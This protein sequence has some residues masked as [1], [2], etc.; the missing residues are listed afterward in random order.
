MSAHA[1]AGTTAAP[2]GPERRPVVHEH[3]GDRR[4]DEYAWLRDRDDPAVIAHLEAENA[5]TEASLAHIEP[6]RE[7]LYQEIVARIQETDASAPVP[8]GPFLYWTRTEQGHQYAVHCRR[9]REPADAAAEV[10]LDVNALAEGHDFTR[11]GD[12]AVSP[13]HSLLAHTVDHAGNERHSLRIRDL[14][15]GVDLDDVVEGV[16]Y[17]LAWASDSRTV[18]YTRPDHAMRPHQVWRHRVGTDPESDALVHQEDDERFFVEVSRT[19]S[20]RWILIELGSYTTSEAWLVPA[21][22][23]ATPPRVVSARRPGVEYSVDH[24]VDAEGRERLYIVTNDG[25][26][27]FRLVE[28]PIDATEHHHWSPVLPHDEGVRLERISCFAGFLAVWERAA[29]LRRV[30]TLCLPHAGR[31]PVELEQPEPV[32]TVTPGDN[33]EWATSTLR[34]EFTSLVTPLQTVEHDVVTG[35]RAV[36]KQVPVLGGYD[37]LRYRSERLWATAPDGVRVPMSVVRR[38]DVPA[39]GTAPALLYGYGSYEVSVDPAFSSLRLSLLDRGVVFAVAHVRGGGELGRPWYE[40]GRLQSKPNTFTDFV[41]CAECL[42][43]EG[44]TSADR[45]AIRGRSAG[46]L[47]IGATVNLRPDLARVAVAEVPFVD[48]LTTML[49]PSIPL[50]VIEWEQ[51]GNP[52]EP[53]AYAAMRAYSPYDNVAEVAHPAML[54]VG[55][56]NDT[57]VAF[58]EP[59]KWVARLRDRDRGGGPFLLRMEMG[60]GHGGKSGRYEAWRD[61]ALVQ[62]FLLDRLPGWT[63]PQV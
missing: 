1:T 44:L 53:Q 62:A 10:I 35:E 47:L 51:W 20:G 22:A 43:A 12:V 41:A 42:V 56:L 49:D 13:D 28:C 60:A 31:D 40:A 50:T 7:R 19:R 15:R 33:R 48:V 29:G 23:P 34:Y 37:P 3:H 8:D 38:V 21:D 2:P 11:V 32:G 16:Y 39:D 30:R 14:E 61:E 26:L 6:L 36:V 63:E 54:V 24:H 9:R 46:G 57:R 59:A 5:H 58:W 18:F 27:N 25:A 4:T 55:G 45:L 52:H 17:S